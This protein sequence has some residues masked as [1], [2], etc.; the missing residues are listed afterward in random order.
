VLANPISEEM[1]VMRPSLP[2]GLLAAARRNMRAA[3][4]A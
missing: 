2:P 3:P 1:K 4:T